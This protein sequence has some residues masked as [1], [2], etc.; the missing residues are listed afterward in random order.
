MFREDYTA[1]YILHESSLLREYGHLCCTKFLNN[2]LTL[3]SVGVSSFS[4]AFLKSF[5]NK[6]PIT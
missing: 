6:N 2:I 3:N 5:P 4:E 1:L